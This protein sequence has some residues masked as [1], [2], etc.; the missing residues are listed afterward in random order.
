MSKLSPLIVLYA[1]AVPLAL[2]LGY[3]VATPDVVSFV[4]VLSLLSVLTLPLFLRWHHFMLILFWNAG[5]DA[6][7]LPGQPHFWL[8]F[9]ALSLGISTVNFVMGRHK[10]LRAT[11]ITKP[12]L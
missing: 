3:L 6:F 11:E 9:A 5:L 8:V 10:F 7:F 12:L 4:V 2:M 1:V